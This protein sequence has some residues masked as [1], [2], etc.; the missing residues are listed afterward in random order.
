MHHSNT[1]VRISQDY[2]EGFFSWHPYMFTLDEDH[3][4]LNFMVS[5]LYSLMHI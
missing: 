1:V 4:R 3:H 5:S 2:G